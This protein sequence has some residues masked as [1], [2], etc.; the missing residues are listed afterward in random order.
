MNIAANIQPVLER[1][2][3]DRLLAASGTDAPVLGRIGTLAVR[4]AKSDSEIDAALALRYRVFFGEAQ[5]S[6]D[7]AR[8]RDRFDEACDHLLVFDRSII[9]PQE[10]QIVGTYRL[11][12]QEQA[13]LSDGYYS[14]REFDVCGLVNRHSNRHFLELGRSCV[15]PQYRAK[16]TVEL[17]WQGIWAY[18]RAH[19]IDVMFGCASFPGTFPAQHAL[20]LSFLHHHARAMGDW[21]VDALGDQAVSMDLMPVEAID[22]K[23]AL[24]AMPP[25]IKGYLRLGAKFG[26]GAV[27]DAEFGSTDVFVI[28]RTEEISDRYL[29]HYGAEAT[30]FV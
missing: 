29:N 24:A 11:L 9:G 21:H 2:P 27:V 13:L 10:S 20:P 26:A 16:R 5:A 30:R 15:L 28:V 14:E 19:G 7:A 6:K 8:D 23:S 12:R 4:L 3:F 25:L 22:L 17:L 1:A 18:C